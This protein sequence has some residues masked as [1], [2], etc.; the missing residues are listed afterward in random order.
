MDRKSAPQKQP[1][2][3]PNPSRIDGTSRK[4]QDGQP[5]FPENEG[6]TSQKT[7]EASD[8]E[9]AE[10]DQTRRDGEAAAQRGRVI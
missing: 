10:G 5:S 9:R 7:R 3:P 1:K 8:I 4:Q 6:L 2:P